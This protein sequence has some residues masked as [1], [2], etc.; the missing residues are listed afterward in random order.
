MKRLIA[1]LF[2]APLMFVGPVAFA[3]SDFEVKL[4]E[5]P[6]AARDTVKRE[7][8]DG[9]ITEIDR[10]AKGGRTFY[11]VEFTQNNQ[12]FEIHVGEDGKLM[13]RRND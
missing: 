6:Q 10:D 7:V 2:I 13:S 3:D 11:E 9:K 8:K 5:M 4:D 1:T 12:R